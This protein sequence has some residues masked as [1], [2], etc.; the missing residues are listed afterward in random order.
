MT[1]RAFLESTEGLQ[2][3]RPRWEVIHRD[4]EVSSPGIPVTNLGVAATDEN[5]HAS[6]QVNLGENVDGV[7]PKARA[8]RLH[9]ILLNSVSHDLRTPL[10]SILGSATTLR[11]CRQNLDDA[12]Q[13]ELIGIIQDEAERLNRFIANLLDMTRLDAGAIRPRLDLVDLEDIIGGALERASTALASHRV[14][15][16][17]AGNLPMLR[18]NP[19]LLEQVVFNLLDNAAKFAPRGTEVRLTA[20]HYA[21]LVRLQVLDEGEGVQLV[22]LERIFDKFYRI[23]GAN[24]KPTG[25]GLDLSICRGFVELMGGTIGASNR[26]NRTGSVFTIILPAPA[27]AFGPLETEVFR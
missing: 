12:A 13:D 22:E 3:E 9:S 23:W 24:S 20:A 1:V 7:C 4:I 21:G 10:T 2:P 26:P 27:D 5:V 19:V 15:L 17:L 11:A 8:E 16:E 14:V 18:L 25:M 6:E